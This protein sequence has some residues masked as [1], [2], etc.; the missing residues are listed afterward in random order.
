MK[1]TYNTASPVGIFDSG[2]GGL[3]VLDVLRGVLPNED[4]VY[5]GDT[6]H[7][8]YGE[9]SPQEIALLAKGIV[10]T[11]VQTYQVKCIVVACNT[12]AGILSDYWRLAAS[13]NGCPVMA[14][15]PAGPICEVLAREDRYESLGLLATQN[16]VHSDLYGKTLRSLKPSAQLTSVACLGLAKL[17]EDGEVDSPSGRELLLGFLEPLVSASVEAIILGCTHYPFATSVIAELLPA[18][19]P[20]ELLDP[21]LEMGKLLQ[22]QLSDKGLRNQN[23]KTGEL[24]YLVTGNPKAFDASAKRLPLKNLAHIVSEPVQVLDPV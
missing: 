7:M 10:R 6:A 8:P 3:S 4:F 1:P 23:T 22:A 14:I 24:R 9:R 19:R 21:A 15:E 11:L 13:E 2:V 17:V 16:T 12:S 20:I 18:D 5:V